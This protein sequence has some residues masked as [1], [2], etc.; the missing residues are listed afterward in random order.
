MTDIVIAADL[1]GEKDT[2]RSSRVPKWVIYLV[3]HVIVV[4]TIIGGWQFTS[5]RW[6]SSLTISSPAEIFT[7]ARNW[8]GQGYLQLHTW[9]T[10]QAV[11][12]GF[13]VGSFLALALAVLFTEIRW[14]GDLGEPYV[15]ALSVVPPI[16]L[17]PVF[18]I[19]FGLG[20]SV[21]I[22]MG[23]LATFF[24]VF[25][26]SFQGLREFNSNLLEL[27]R[28]LGATRF[29]RLF[30]FQ[31]WAALPFF[32]SGA[33]LALPKACLAVVVAEF[34]TGNRGL[35]YAILRAGNNLDM[36]GFFVGVIT[37][38]VV[39]FLL[40]SLLL[41]IEQTALAWVPKERK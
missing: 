12:L 21:K 29:Q 18:I 36:G 24:I 16:A 39:V 31:L 9:H 20:I 33:K 8:I 30:K 5:D 1:D 13:F 40:S 38:T 27:S 17:I 3:V 2:R 7:V 35:G 10:F 19:W 34:L 37:L 23:V 28:L 4:L 32:L 26:T 6:I 25:I 15:I 11:L 22:I 41:M 14:L